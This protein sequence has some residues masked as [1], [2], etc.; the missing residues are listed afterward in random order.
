VTDDQQQPSPWVAP[1][2][3]PAEPSSPP[4]ASPPP[5]YSHPRQ[6]AYPQRYADQLRPAH[7]PGIIALRPLGLGDLYDGAFN[8][9]RRNPKP[10]VGLAAIVSTSAL[11]VPAL[12]T[13][14]LAAA[15]DL[16]FDVNSDMGAAQAVTYAGSAMTALAS[17]LLTGMIVHVVMEAALGRKATIEQTWRAVRGRMLQLIGLAL[18]TAFVAILLVGTPIVVGIV[19][20]MA[21]L[22]LGLVVGIVGF[23]AAACAAV[24][25]WTRLVL[26]A[27]PA[28]VVERLG[29]FS[30]MNRAW[31][32]SKGQ[33]WRIFGI[34]LLTQLVVGVV[35]QI[36]A[37]PLAV[38]A[39]AGAFLIDDP[40]VAALV[41]VFANYVS[42]ILGQALST[43]FS[44]AVQALQYVDQRIR[45][46]AYDVE[47]IAR[48]QQ[49]AAVA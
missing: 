47:L 36:L 46:E 13:V 22:A 15:G 40:T 6:Y 33:F 48:S 5:A 28:M 37:V 8:A 14:L 1:G 35:S 34:A 3:S 20:G 31:A 7:K 25:L 19:L 17:I 18:L 44:A 29:V 49:P 41:Y 10:M 27:P 43:P 38:V 39:V 24:F 4:E 23:I 42:L 9:I 12:V 21:N 2:S 30:S 16:S 11:L 32:L 45:K 26:L